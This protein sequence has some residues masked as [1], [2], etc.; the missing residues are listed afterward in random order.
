MFIQ[1]NLISYC[2]SE[3]SEKANI[4]IQDN[5]DTKDKHSASEDDDSTANQILIT[6]GSGKLED[7]W[8]KEDFL[9]CINVLICKILTFQWQ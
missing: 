3:L 9:V 1:D 5:D 6:I 2:S 4:D 8:V 7:Y